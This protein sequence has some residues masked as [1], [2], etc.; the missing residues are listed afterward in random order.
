MLSQGFFR[1]TRLSQRNI[2]KFY[3]LKWLVIGLGHFYFGYILVSYFVGVEF[4]LVLG[5]TAYFSQWL[6]KFVCKSEIMALI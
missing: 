6:G 3:R 2:V 5:S 1:Y 4:T